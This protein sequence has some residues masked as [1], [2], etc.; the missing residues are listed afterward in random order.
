MQRLSAAILGAIFLCTPCGSAA[1]NVDHFD[2]VREFQDPPPLAFDRFRYGSAEDEMVTI[3]VPRRAQ[4]VPLII[5]FPWPSV[6]M[7]TH[8]DTSWMRSFLFNA[9]VA[10]ARIRLPDASHRAL[11]DFLDSCVRALAEIARQ[12]RRFGYDESR[13]ILAGWGWSSHPAALFALDPSYAQKSGVPFENIRGLLLI[14][15]AGLDLDGERR[16]ASNHVARQIAKLLPQA[17]AEG[18]YSPL[19]HAAPPNIPEALV[20]NSRKARDRGMLDA[21]IAE[22]LR[23]SGVAV[24]L[25]SLTAASSDVR[26]SMIGGPGHSANPL[27]E[28]F[29][30]RTV[31]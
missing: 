20:L 13:I 16:L 12:G 6:D 19:S 4:P 5:W 26:R 24:T 11:P 22:T 31:R 8:Q 23:A 30:E 7:A 10:T 18:A 15:P 9:G 17:P 3:T 1:Q 21:K 29:L 25:E 28:S 27:I 2:E 14:E